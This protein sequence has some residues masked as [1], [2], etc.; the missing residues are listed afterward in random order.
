V[1][2]FNVL[3]RKCLRCNTDRRYRKHSYRA[4]NTDPNAGIV[5]LK[6]DDAVLYEVRWGR[7]CIAFLSVD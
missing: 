4:L 3:T 5:G 7:S 1:T 2:L 6:W